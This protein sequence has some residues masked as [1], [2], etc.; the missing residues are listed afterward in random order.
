MTQLQQRTALTTRILLGAI[1]ASLC[2]STAWALYALFV[3]HEGNREPVEVKIPDVSGV[4][5]DGGANY[6]AMLERPLFWPERAPAPPGEAVAGVAAQGAAGP[7]GLVYLGVILKGDVKQ[8]LLQDSDGVRVL[9]EGER[10]RGLEIRRIS[11]EGVTLAGSSGEVHLP[12]PVDNSES[13][14]I[15]QLQ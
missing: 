4:R 15:R 9:H 8:A 11:A 13:I 3:S 1:A 14:E 2:L 7:E 6:P 5:F 12:A 10:I